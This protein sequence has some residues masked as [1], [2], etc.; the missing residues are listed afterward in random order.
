MSVIQG[1]W[2]LLLLP[3]SLYD[4]KFLVF[5]LWDGISASDVYLEDNMNV[6]VFIL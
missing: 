2:Y 6:W 5:I 1:A 3:L 4:L